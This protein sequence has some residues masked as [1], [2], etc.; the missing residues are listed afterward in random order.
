[1]GPKLGPVEEL[2][3]VI[4]YSGVMHK[5]TIKISGSEDSRLLLK[6]EFAALSVLNNLSVAGSAVLFNVDCPIVVHS[7]LGYK[8]LSDLR[9]VTSTPTANEVVQIGITGLDILK[10]LHGIGVVHGA[11][12]WY[13]LRLHPTSLYD[14][15]LTDFWI[16]SDLYVT[17]DGKLKTDTTRSSSYFTQAPLGYRSLFYLQDMVNGFTNSASVLLP[18]RRDDLLNF[19][20]ALLMLVFGDRGVFEPGLDIR[21]VYE[22]KRSLGLDPQRVDVR[23]YAFY[24]RCRELDWMAAP[25]YDKLKSDLLGSA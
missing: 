8:S 3:G 19:A 9:T 22:R 14:I 2:R 20:E 24:R 25:D 6:R 4:S 15:R 11:V 7:Y 23:L 13:T 16:G 12:N 10:R 18:S 5:I 21:Q 17:M 1:L